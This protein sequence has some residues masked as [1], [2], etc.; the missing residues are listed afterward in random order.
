MA[1][2]RRCFDILAIARPRAMM[3]ECAGEQRRLRLLGNCIQSNPPTIEARPGARCGR[4]LSMFR[5]CLPRQ[6]IGKPVTRESLIEAHHRPPSLG[7]QGRETVLAPTT[8]ARPRA[9]VEHLRA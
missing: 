3:R 9:E 7:A 1:E 6:R 4:S 5:E 8:R 2:V